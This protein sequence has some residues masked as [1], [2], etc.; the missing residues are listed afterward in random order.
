M[1]KGFEFELST[2]KE[3]RNVCDKK[4]KVAMAVESI[5]KLPE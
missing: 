4:K 3:K 2:P 1:S 5:I